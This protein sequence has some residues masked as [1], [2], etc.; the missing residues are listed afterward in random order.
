[1]AS[2]VDDVYFFGGVF[3]SIRSRKPVIETTLT[4]DPNTVRPGDT[5]TFTS[6][7]KNVGDDDGTD[8]VIRHPIPDG[9]TYVPGSIRVVSGPEP[10][11]NGPKSDREGDD[12]AEVVMDPMTGKPVLVIRIGRGASGN[13]GGKLTP[14]DVPVVVEYKLKTAP[15]A[16]GN[17]PTQSQTSANTGGNP[18]LPTATFPSGNGMQ[19]GAPTV[20]HVPDGAA[21]LRITVTKTPQNPEP[22]TPVTYG[23]DVKN[24]GTTTD[25]GPINVKVTI[26]PGGKI[27]SVKPGPGWTCVQQDRTVMCTRPTPMPAG[28][29]SHV[30]DIVVRNPGAVAEDNAVNAR[31]DSE[32]AYDPNPA[33]NVW[34]ELGSNLR[35][36]GGGTGCSLSPVATHSGADA[37][38][39]IGAVMVALALLR[40]RSAQRTD[41]SARV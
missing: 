31:V 40:R 6:T 32:G 25:P 36:A 37:L 22:N 23:V 34:N 16:K 9:L 5:V 4:A 38:A 41:V 12:Q 24:V 21:D 13:M 35:I 14:T 29:N 30:A 11:Q 19:P 20:V 10:T 26:P 33:D 27:D 39:G 1:V 2:S 7:T 17:I 3:T 28:E 15:T 18:G 8:I